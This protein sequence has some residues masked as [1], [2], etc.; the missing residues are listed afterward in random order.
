MSDIVLV[1][2]GAGYIGSHTCKELARNCMEPV[3]LDNLVYGHREFVRW[4]P[5]VEGDIHDG[6]LLDQL[7]QKYRFSAVIHF[8][9][10]A[11][12]GESVQDPGKYYRNNVAG[13]LSLLEAMR[14]N[15][16]R[17]I[18]FS[19]TCATYGAPEN[20]LIGEE[21][22][23]QP[24]N[25]YGRGK[26]MV[27]T[28]LKD[29]ESAYAMRHG[30]LRYFNAAGADPA[31]EIG[32]RH[33]PET[34]LVPLAIQAAMGQGKALTRFGDDYPTP[35]GTAIREYIHV[36]DLADAH[37]RALAFLRNEER[38]IVCNLGT[39]RG[40]SVQEV[41]EAVGRR[42]GNEVP[43]IQ[44]PRRPGD[45]PQLVSTSDR[46]DRLL[47]WIPRRSAIETIVADA[48][49]WHSKDSRR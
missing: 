15:A 1:T 13:T 5:F 8:A 14:R 34:H 38:S 20:L 24:I 11:Y 10:Y 16:C 4:G 3:S 39:G 32:E 35:D 36:S 46:A 18:I 12:V 43:V 42:G 47:G 49:R 25:P 27:E 31:A 40:S 21:T 6:Q 30:I 29:Y 48:W 23:Q 19:S 9:A 44:G 45:P 26:L 28:I 22:A 33:N 17:N 37:V 7:F 2:G 41:V